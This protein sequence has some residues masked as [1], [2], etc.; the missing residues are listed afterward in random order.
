M[1]VL[2]VGGGKIG[3]Y[4]TKTLMGMGHKVS[5]IEMSAKHSRE[6]ADEFGINVINGDGTK[7]DDLRNADAQD[8]DFM[9]AVTGKDEDNLISC[10]LSKKNFNVRRTIARVNNPKNIKV[11]ERLGVDKAVSSTS[12]IADI[13]EHEVDYEGVTT[14]MRLRDGKICIYEVSIPSNSKNVAKSLKDIKVPHD[15]V[16]TSIIRRN[17]A[18]IPNGLTAIDADDIMIVV[19]STD[20]RERIHDLFIG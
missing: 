5:V 6:I 3:Y 19:S 10:Q 8:A 17:E 9:I 2:I 11:F 4:L 20:D 16:V 12:I 14:L 1:K 18:I 13:I 15:C 7:L